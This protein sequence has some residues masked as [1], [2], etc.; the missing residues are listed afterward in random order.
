MGS[1][2][3]A[4]TSSLQEQQPLFVQQKERF[5][6]R[7]PR[8]VQNGVTT[9][10]TAGAHQKEFGTQQVHAEL[11]GRLEQPLQPEFEQRFVLR[12]RL[13]EYGAYS[14]EPRFWVEKGEKRAV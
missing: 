10:E 3:K 8:Y 6:H 13:G 4:K 5:R 14:Q 7:K 2:K 11:P 1:Q 12:G 9:P